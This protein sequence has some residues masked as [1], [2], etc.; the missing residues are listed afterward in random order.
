MRSGVTLPPGA[1][2]LDSEMW[3][4]RES[5]TAPAPLQVHPETRVPHISILRCGHRA[6]ARPLPPLSQPSTTPPKSENKSQKTPPK[7]THNPHVNPPSTHKNDK[8][9]APTAHF[10]PTH[11]AYLPPPTR[12]NLT[13]PP[14]PTQTPVRPL[15]PRDTLPLNPPAFNALQPEITPE[16][17]ILCPLTPTPSITY[18]PKSLLKGGY[19][20][21]PPPPTPPR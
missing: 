11:L 15:K 21:P 12:Y 1:P 19:P 18:E 14:H 20:T 16:T 8:T 3:A 7:T 5:A 6:K 13:R 4:S 9:C 17:G 2:Y 10:S